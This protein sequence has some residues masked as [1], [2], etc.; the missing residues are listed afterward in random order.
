MQSC[1]SRLTSDEDDM[2]MTATR[3]VWF[4]YSTR[5]LHSAHFNVSITVRKSQEGNNREV[6]LH[7][8]IGDRAPSIPVPLAILFSMVTRQSGADRVVAFSP[9]HYLRNEPR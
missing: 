3:L 4:A 2:T 1:T 5:N 9:S 7:Y 8:L 6:G